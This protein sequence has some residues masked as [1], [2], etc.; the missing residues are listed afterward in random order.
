MAETNSTVDNTTPFI[1]NTLTAFNPPNQIIAI[2]AATQLPLKLTE[3]N[4]L[5]W[6]VQYQSLLFGYDL[7]GYIDGSFPFPPSSITNPYTTNPIPN[8]AYHL[9]KRQDS[10]IFN[11]MLASVFDSIVPLIT[12]AR[13][14]VEAWTRLE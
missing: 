5:S 1:T 4:Y 10:L 7:D 14:A 3:I 12:S 11:A 8:P 13:S 6:R 9:W 2:D